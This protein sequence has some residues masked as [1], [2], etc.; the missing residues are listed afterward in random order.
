M[1]TTNL[2]KN[3]ARPAGE[4][5]HVSTFGGD[6]TDV[7]FQADKPISWYL[8]AADITVANGQTIS[9]NGSETTAG[10]VLESSPGRVNTVVVASEVANG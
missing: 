8:N 6:V 7:P 10:T 5:V 3:D 4:V 9:L 2:D 1:Q